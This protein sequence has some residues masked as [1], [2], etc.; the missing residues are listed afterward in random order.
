MTNALLPLFFLLPTLANGGDTSADEPVA[1]VY[2]LS[3]LF[4]AA[5]GS[6]SADRVFPL[7]HGEPDEADGDERELDRELPRQILRGLLAGDFEAKGVDVEDA[8]DERLIVR[9]TPAVHERVRASLAAID[10]ALA[11]SL[12]LELCVLRLEGASDLRA[13][14]VPEAQAA[15]WIDAAAGAGRLQRM[16]VRVGRGTVGTVDVGHQSDFLGDFDV[17]VA[18]GAQTFDPVMFPLRLGTSLSLRASAGRGGHFVAL[19]LRRASPS[20]ELRR[21]TLERATGLL[22]GDTLLNR[23][24]GIQQ[25]SQPVLGRSLALNAFLPEGQALVVLLE[26]APAGVREALVLRAVGGG[27]PAPGRLTAGP[28]GQDMALLDATRWSPPAAVGSLRELLAVAPETLP[29]PRLGEGQVWMGTRPSGPDEDP[30]ELLE[31][32]LELGASQPDLSEGWWPLRAVTLDEVEA[33]RLEDFAPTGG[34]VTVGLALRRGERVLAEVEL[35]LLV[36][37]DSEL[38]LCSEDLYVFDADVEIAKYSSVEDPV[39]REV[40]EGLFASLRPLRSP[41]GALLLELRVAGVSPAGARRTLALADSASG[42]IE[43]QAHDYL[44]AD[45]LLR[46][47]P[48]VGARTV[49]LG[50]AAG[51]LALDVTLI[52]G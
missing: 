22:A 18:E 9:A 12:E 11:A 6:A 1:R 8:G 10:R 23:T 30:G 3:G 19:A 7:L 13:G 24:R 28:G 20:G 39:A 52:D 34:N 29:Y 40:L 49:R 38:V 17:E 33:R 4:V 16:A 41:S 32:A 50:D 45:E 26:H 48:G 43:A 47:E 46:L 31:R 51:G 35:P 27:L 15:A 37:R 42:Q 2:D 5:D 44:V 21:R 14:T 36:G 25:E